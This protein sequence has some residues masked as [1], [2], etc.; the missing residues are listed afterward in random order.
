MGTDREFWTR[1]A[2]SIVRNGS[3]FLY[4]YLSSSFVLHFPLSLV[5][6]FISVTVIE[7][8]DRSD[9][10]GRERDRDTDKKQV[11]VRYD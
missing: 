8:P 3:P 10:E 9:L 6:S 7:Y 4:L 11:R 5:P 1:T 2:D